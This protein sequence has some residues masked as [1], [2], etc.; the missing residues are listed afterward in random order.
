VNWADQRNGKE[1]VDVF[2]I[3]S[4]DNGKSWSDVIKVNQD[5]SKH[6]QFF[7]WMDIDQ[8]NG[9]L[10]FVFYD[11][12]NYS[13]NQ[14]DVY[15]AY[16]FDGGSNISDVRISGSPFMPNPDVFFG[17]YINIAV[18]KGTVR[19]IWMRMDEKKISLWTALIEGGDLK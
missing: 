16:S 11:R 19:P 2:C 17:D 14:T 12:R 3:Y 13:D 9:N 18:H 1:N 10:Y 5:V 7:T 4:D 15:L 6:H 8:S